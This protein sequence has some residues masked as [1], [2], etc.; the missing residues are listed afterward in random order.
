MMKGLQARVTARLNAIETALEA[1]ASLLESVLS[2]QHVLMMT[3]PPSPP[4]MSAETGVVAQ[5]PSL[6]LRQ[7]ND[8]VGGDINGG[9]DDDKNNDDDVDDRGDGD[10]HGAKA[11]RRRAAS[12]ARRLS[13]LPHSA[14]DLPLGASAPTPW[15]AGGTAGLPMPVPMP[16]EFPW[17][18][19]S[20]EPA[21]WNQP[22]S[23]PAAAMPPPTF[24]SM[25]GD[26]PAGGADPNLNMFRGCIPFPAPAIWM[27]PWHPAHAPLLGDP[28]M[29][30]IRPGLAPPLHDY[31]HYGGPSAGLDAQAEP[32]WPS[33]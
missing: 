22:G 13:P 17:M 23:G 26:W 9:G 25:F 28:A 2:S 16:G 31:H 3:Q 8:G 5:L 14:A 30:G 1:Q 29:S 21:L 19:S 6:Q 18:P 11:N 4:L 12:R 10:R 24:F 20:M 33:P 7:S 27:P 32:L 15:L